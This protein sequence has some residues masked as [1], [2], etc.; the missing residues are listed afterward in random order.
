M[1]TEELKRRRNVERSGDV[2]RLNLPDAG[3]KKKRRI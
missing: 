3:N 2:G 1:A